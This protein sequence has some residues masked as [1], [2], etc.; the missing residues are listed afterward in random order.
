MVFLGLAVLGY[1]RYIRRLKDSDPAAAEAK[2]APS[3]E[4]MVRAEVG[5]AV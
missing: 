5:V 1:E 2:L 3:A 4:Q